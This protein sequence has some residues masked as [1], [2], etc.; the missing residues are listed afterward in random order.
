[1]NMQTNLSSITPENYLVITAMVV[2]LGDSCFSF[3]RK[4][5]G[6]SMGVSLAGLFLAGIS[7][8]RLLSS[9]SLGKTFGGALISDRF[10]HSVELL[11]EL[12]AVLA[13]LMAGGYLNNRSQSSQHGYVNSGAMRSGSFRSAQFRH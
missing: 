6:L 13:V 11:L 9:D 3:W 5:K 10:T 1:M 2:L 12:V 8:Y 7:S 4:A